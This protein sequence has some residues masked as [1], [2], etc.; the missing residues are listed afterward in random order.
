M[1]KSF[2]HLICSLTIVSI[3]LNL[4]FSINQLPS[5]GLI[6]VAMVFGITVIFIQIF[7]ISENAINEVFILSKHFSFV[8]IGSILSIGLLNPEFF[9]R[10]DDLSL[11]LQGCSITSIFTIIYYYSIFG[12][13][14]NKIMYNKLNLED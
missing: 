5:M 12:K 6:L 2:A 4:I 13:Y 14:F 1:W 3:L 10:E 9:I 7:N 11:V 8:F